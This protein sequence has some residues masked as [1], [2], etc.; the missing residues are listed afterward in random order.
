MYQ[1]AA[2]LGAKKRT[3]VC[4]IC[5]E[6]ADIVL[7]IYTLNRQTEVVNSKLKQVP[8]WN[9]VNNMRGNIIS[10]L[11]PNRVQLEFLKVF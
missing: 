7:L 9:K 8:K 3:I 11:Y 2:A 5:S 1:D 4:V 10:K 6:I